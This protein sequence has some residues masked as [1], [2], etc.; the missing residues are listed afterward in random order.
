MILGPVIFQILCSRSLVKLIL[1]LRL[2]ASNQWNCISMAFNALG[3]I[4]LVSSLCAVKLLV[5]MGVQVCRCPSSSSVHRIKTTVLA[6]M[7]SVPISASTANNI[8]V[9]II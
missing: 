2:V 8:T 1:V 7:N 6:L 4:L 3:R 9:L 5:W